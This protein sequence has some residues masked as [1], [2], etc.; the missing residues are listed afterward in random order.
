MDRKSENIRIKLGAMLLSLCLIIGL[1]PMTVLAYGTGS[2]GYV[3]AHVKAVFSNAVETAGA[4]YHICVATVKD[5]SG[6][7]VLHYVYSS[8]SIWNVQ[9]FNSVR[10]RLAEPYQSLIPI[11]EKDDNNKKGFLFL[12]DNQYKDMELDWTDP[13][14]VAEELIPGSG[15]VTIKETT[16]SVLMGTSTDI[17][18]DYCSDYDEKAVETINEVG[19]TITRPTGANI[20]EAINNVAKGGPYYIVEGGITKECYD[21][22]IFILVSQ[23]SAYTVTKTV[24]VS[25]FIDLPVQVLEEGN[26]EYAPAPQLSAAF[27][28]DAAVTVGEFNERQG[29]AINYRKKDAEAYGPVSDGYD[30][31]AIYTVTFPLENY[32]VK[33]LGGIL[34]IPLPEGYD[35]ASAR[36]K[37]GAKASSHTADTVSFPVTLDVSGGLAEALELVIEYKIVTEA[38]VIIKGANGIWHKGEKDGLSF[39]SNAAFADFQKIQVDG[40]DLDASNYTVKEGSTIVTLKPSYLD[41]LSAGRHTLSIVSSSGTASTEFTIMAAEVAD[42]EIN[43][44]Q[45]GDNSNVAIWFALLV[46][47]A[48]SL[49][50]T[51]AYRRRKNF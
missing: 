11:L 8:D 37:G 47:S 41:T 4:D 16:S 23:L 22:V 46:I 21:V 20:I 14:A 3:K 34:T 32:Q 43:L 2:I 9:L 42:K 1:M 6:D 27:T 28:S 12:S 24:P 50:G 17:I 33:T 25:N 19:E 49:T 15:T 51:I 13:A 5:E 7:F 10:D 36:I 18:D 26:A 38:P 44:P 29:L 39:T 31:Q 30:F 45:T 35:G 48:C 40:K